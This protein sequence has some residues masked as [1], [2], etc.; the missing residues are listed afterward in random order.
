[1]RRPLPVSHPTAGGGVGSG[2][3]SLAVVWSFAPSSPVSARRRGGTVDRA[4]RRG[5]PT[6]GVNRYAGPRAHDRRM[7]SAVPSTARDVGLVVAAAQAPGTFAP[8][9][10]ARSAVD[11]GLVTGLADRPALPARGRHPGRAPGRGA[12]SAGRLRRSPAAPAGRARSPPTSAA[13]PLGLARAAGAPAPAGRADARGCCGSRPGAPR[14]RRRRRAG[15]AAQPALRARRRPAGCRRPARRGPV[16]GAGRARRGVRWWT[17][18]G[19][20]E[21]DDGRAGRSAEPAPPALL[22]DRRRGGGRP[23]RRRPTASTSSPTS[24]AGGWRPCCPAGRSCGGWRAR[25]FLACLAPG[26]RSVWAGRCGDR[27]RGV[28]R[29]A[30]ARRR[31]GDPLD[32]ADR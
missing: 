17:A 29:R 28:G 8:S 7:D 26:R 11:Q 5:T 30:R 25:G 1:M 21:R 32:R 10:S 16:R 15:G 2:S 3:G 31:R 6:A 22:A 18:G 24:P 19:A 14:H 12:G 20:G 23:G 27:G 13:V 4:E 9:L